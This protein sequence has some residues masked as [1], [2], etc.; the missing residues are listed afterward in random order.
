MKR[1]SG[2]W[3]TIEGPYREVARRKW[4]NPWLLGF[5][6]IALASASCLS[7]KP[8]LSPSVAPPDITR[9][10]KAVS[11][12]WSIVIKVEPNERLPKGGNGQGEEVWR[13]GPGGV[14][15]IEEYHSTGNEGEISG[16]GI[17]WWDKD[18]RRFH[19]AWCDSSSSPSC[20]VMTRGAWWQENNLVL[21]ND[22][23]DAGKQLIF[24]EIFS[25]I[26]DSSFTQTLYEGQSAEDLRSVVTIRARRK[27]TPAT[28]T[29]LDIR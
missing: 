11:G 25:D 5:V 20:S 13:P 24:R 3:E 26:T 8:T 12:A 19:V 6:L 7:Q 2:G 29:P 9:L 16:V 14:S 10:A 1:G 18:T 22:S 21:E 28:S 4:L 17:F 27:E 15:F 23:D